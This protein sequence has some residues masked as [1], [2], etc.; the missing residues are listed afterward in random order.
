MPD[1][2][3]LL[4]SVFEN[5][6]DDDATDHQG[7]IVA[8]EWL[9]EKSEDLDFENSD[10]VIRVPMPKFALPNPPMLEE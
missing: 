2:G 3:Y 7:E 9:P 10:L 8:G 6:V 1:S 5:E 4:Y